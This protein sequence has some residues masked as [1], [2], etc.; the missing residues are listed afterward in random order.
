MIFR[1]HQAKDLMAAQ[2]LC[3]VCCYLSTN[4]KP[5]LRRFPASNSGSARSGVQLV[6]VK[7]AFPLDAGFAAPVTF[8]CLKLAPLKSWQTQALRQNGWHLTQARFAS[9]CMAAVTQTL[10]SAQLQP[11]LDFCTA[12]IPFHPYL[13]RVLLQ[14][15]QV[16]HTWNAST[17]ETEIL[18]CMSSGRL[19]TRSVSRSAWPA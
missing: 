5:V 10:R 17:L 14:A 9:C 3:G 13:C 7:A 4:I 16:E 6:L 12:E 11:L 8:C 15:D 1:L 18:R 19:A 2:D